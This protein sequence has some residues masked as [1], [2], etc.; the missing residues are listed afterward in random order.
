MY[1]PQPEEQ[2]R[3][4]H[5]FVGEWTW[6]TETIPGHAHP[7]MTGMETARLIGEFWVELSG[8]GGHGPTRVTL[9]FDPVTARFVGTWVGGSMPHLWVYSGERSSDGQTLVLHT[10]GPAMDRSGTTAYR[11][12][13]TFVGP[14]ERTLKAFYQTSSGAWEHFMTTRYRRVGSA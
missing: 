3:W 5:Q 10:T 4:L 9:G 13:F 8:D 12:E 14:N 1:A 2:H 6:A 11:D 7:T